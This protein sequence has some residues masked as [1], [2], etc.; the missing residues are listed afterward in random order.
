MNTSFSFKKFTR[1]VFKFILIIVALIG[2]LIGGFYISIYITKKQNL[3]QAIE[4][5]KECAAKTHIEDQPLFDFKYFKDDEIKEINFKIIRDHIF[6]KDTT[7]INNESQLY[8]INV[9]FQKFLKTDTILITINNELQ[10]Y[11]SDFTYSVHQ[12]YGMFG[13][14]AV[15]D[16]ETHS[17]KINDNKSLEIVKLYGKL[18]SENKEL[19]QRISNE[20]SKYKEL[21]RNYKITSKKLDNILKEIRK[22]NEYEHYGLN[23]GVEINEKN[24]YYIYLFYYGKGDYDIIKINTNTGEFTKKIKN[25][26]IEHKY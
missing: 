21:I 26:P 15:S 20:N 2:L 9:P 24:S 18:K 5:S 10:Y 1:R 11:L 23:L 25:Y 19:T 16:C 22:V 17:S 13:P 14:I 3:K 12:N 4:K 7:I 8:S 6:I